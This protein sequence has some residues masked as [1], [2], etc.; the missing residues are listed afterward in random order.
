MFLNDIV[1]VTVTATDSPLSQAGFGKALILGPNASG[2]FTAGVYV[3]SYTT[4]AAMLTDGFLSTDSEYLMAVALMSQ[5]KSP[6]SFLVGVQTSQA[7]DTLEL[8][9]TGALTTGTVS[10]RVGQNLITEAFDTDQDTTMQAVATSIAAICTDTVLSATWVDLDKKLTIVTLPGKG[11]SYKTVSIGD[12]TSVAKTYVDDTSSLA[13]DLLA[14]D[15]QDD[16]WYALLISS[17]GRGDLI[18]AATEVNTRKKL[19]GFDM[20]DESVLVSTDST[21]LASTF[22]S[23]T[24]GRVIWMYN[25]DPD[26]YY[27]ASWFGRMLPETPGAAN[28]AYKT[29]VGVPSYKLTSSEQ[30]SINTKRGNMYE[31]IGG[32]NVPYRGILPSGSFVDVLRG[33]DYLAARI[34][35][36]VYALLATADKV[37]YSDAGFSLV[38]ATV[39]SVLLSAT[40]TDLLVRDDYLSV[41]Y[42]KLSEISAADK[43]ARHLPDVKFKG[44]LSGA[45]NTVAIEGVVTLP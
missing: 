42:P 27:M 3:K 15:A 16:S 2:V 12:F 5:K 41:T 33:T 18:Q 25:P 9:F 13:A 17:Q 43:A 30:S 31:E 29:L 44:H 28:W 19:F 22:V 10:L 23:Q 45:V 34:Q 38:G 36:A 6:Q 21:D 4:P 7:Y 40:K 32:V 11:I 20:Y 37:P 14:I 39:Y 35:E 26:Y 8:V 1:K 24:Q